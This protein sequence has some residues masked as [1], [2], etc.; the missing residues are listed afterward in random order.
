[1]LSDM[2][3]LPEVTQAGAEELL[4]AAAAIFHL[5]NKMTDFKVDTGL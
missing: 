4:L 3:L 2:R 1:M 5:N